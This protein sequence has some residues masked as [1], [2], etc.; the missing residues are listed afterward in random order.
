LGGGASLG[1][2]K[3]KNKTNKKPK[4]KATD[5]SC[6]E[7]GGRGQSQGIARPS[8]ATRVGGGGRGGEGVGRDKFREYTHKLELLPRCAKTRV[9]RIFNPRHRVGA[10]ANLGR[11]LGLCLFGLKS[12]QLL[13][14]TDEIP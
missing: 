2:I 10:L 3:E 9:V 14:I 13:C 12:E 7:G 8:G 11:S 1:K 4:K 6:Q 5:W